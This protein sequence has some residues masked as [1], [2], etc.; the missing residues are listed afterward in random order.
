ADDSL[1]NRLWKAFGEHFVLPVRVME[2]I[3]ASDAIAG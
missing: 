1:R 2:F 3:K